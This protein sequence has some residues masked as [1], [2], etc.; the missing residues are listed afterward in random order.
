V[1]AAAGFGRAQA[2]HAGYRGPVGER[3]V[4]DEHD[5][6]CELLLLLEALAVLTAGK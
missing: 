1:I 3:L 5:L 6:P 4:S 2:G